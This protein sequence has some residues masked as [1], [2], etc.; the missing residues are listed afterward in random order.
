MPESS[1]RRAFTLVRF[2]GKPSNLTGIAQV[3]TAQEAH[4]LRARWQA[5]YPDDEVVV[6]DLENQPIDAA[7]LATLALA[8]GTG[9]THP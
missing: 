5:A 6:F 4:A 9:E 8:E 7:L 3:I 1:V 2:V